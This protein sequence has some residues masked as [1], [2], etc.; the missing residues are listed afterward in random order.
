[1]PVKRC[2]KD[3]NG[4]IEGDEMLGAICVDGACDGQPCIIDN[5]DYFCS[6]SYLKT[7][8]PGGGGNQIATPDQSVGLCDAG[9]AGCTEYIDPVSRFS[10]NAVYNPGYQMIDGNI[11][12]WGKTSPTWKGAGVGSTQQAI[13]IIPNKLYSLTVESSD[14]A[15]NG[16]VALDFLDNVKPLLA[17][18]TFGTS[19]KKITLPA[20]SADNPIRIFFH[21]MANSVAL[22][23]GGSSNKTIV[24]RDAVVEYQFR[25]NIDKKS[26]T[27]TN[28]DNGCVLFNERLVNGQNGLSTL[29]WDAFSTDDKQAPVICDEE[30]WGSCTANTLIKVRPDRVCGKWLSCT[31]YAQ[32]P[33]TKKPSICYS[34][35]E[36]DRLDDKNECANFVS[37]PTVSTRLFDASRDRNATGYSVVNEYYL[38]QMKE[39]GLNSEAHYDF[40]ESIPALSCKRNVEFAGGEADCVFDNNSNIAKDSIIR[41]P[42]AKA[43]D[44]PAHGKS[45]LRVPAAIRLRR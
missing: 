5:N 39:V 2:D 23:S 18:N 37:V 14:G 22:V 33:V 34:V 40:E 16:L 36:C 21:S 8:G 10:S 43:T 20:Y 31:S 26:C 42:G 44:Y 35:S 6:V 11:E 28:F 41:E 4:K 27:V 25:N 24:V 15:N 17:D 3:A 13:V 32:D 7:I 45:Y 29:N 9:L 12:G 1:V 30:V 38:A 19:T